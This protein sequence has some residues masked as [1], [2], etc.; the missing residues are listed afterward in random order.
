MKMNVNGRKAWFALMLC[1]MAA[2]PAA[3]QKER[4][5]TFNEDRSQHYMT[6]KVY[7][8]KYVNAHD[9]MPFILGAMKRFDEQAS[10][11]SLDYT[12][13]KK[14]FV[15]ISCGTQMFPYIDEMVAKLDHPTGKTD[16]A[17]SIIDGDGIYRYNYC[18]KY[19]GSDN[20]RS[21]LEQTFTGGI[22]SGASY[23]DASTNMF[24]WKTSK[25]QGDAYLQFLQAIDRPVP[26]VQVSLNLYIVNDNDFQ[27][28]GVDYLGWKNGPGA[29]LFGAGFDYTSISSASSI[30]NAVD[31]ASNVAGSTLGG[32]AVAPQFDATFVRMLAQKGKAK[33]AA[34]AMLTVVNDFGSDADPG[35]DNFDGAKYRFRFTPQFQNLQK[36]DN[37]T[38]SVEAMDGVGELYFYLRTPVIAYNGFETPDKAMTLM[39]GWQLK[40]DDNMEDTNLGATTVNSYKF[41]SYLTLATGAEKLLAVYDKDVYVKQYNGMPFL[42]DI[43]VLKYLVGSEAEVKTKAKVFVTIT[44]TP[45][46]PDAKLSA[47]AGQIITP[48]KV[49]AATEPQK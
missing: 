26:Q 38:M 33:V 12:A 40:V 11:K 1:A 34:S 22:G 41:D 35:L 45:V 17:G 25:S 23:Y 2:F 28:L 20:M 44:A 49:V 8:L 36:D 14:Q 24:Y 46:H 4:T 27:E 37:Q 18:S 47:W 19:R 13:G 5:I 39:C 31:S 30:S 48:E 3:A 10:I 9:V 6:T 15:V 16:K 7:E 29:N 21:V 43:P 32:F 42:G